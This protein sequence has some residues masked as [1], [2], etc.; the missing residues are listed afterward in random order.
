MESDMN[1]FVLD[2]L[3]DETGVSGEGTVAE[4]VIFADG[5]VAMRW[6]TATASTA[7][8]ASIADVIHIHGHGGKTHVRLIDGD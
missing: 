2:R 1:R 4:G 3:V 5:S 6:L 8:Y 7:V